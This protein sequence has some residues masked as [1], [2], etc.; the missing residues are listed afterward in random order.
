[1]GDEIKVRRVAPR[2]EGEQPRSAPPVPSS[3]L[4]E[5]KRQPTATANTTPAVES[6]LAPKPPVS[7]PISSQPSITHTEDPADIAVTDSALASDTTPKPTDNTEPSKPRRNILRGYWHHKL[8]TIPLT[9]LLLIGAFFAVPTTRYMALAYFV[10]R[11]LTVTVTDSTTHT[12][13]SGAQVKIDGQ[14]KLTGSDGKVKFTLP[15]GNHTMQVTKSYY[16][17]AHKS[18]FVD[19]SSSNNVLGVELVATGRQVPLQVINKITGKAIPEAELTIG[20]ATARTDLRGAATAVLPAD[21]A[22][23]TVIIKADGYNDFTGTVTITTDTVAANTFSMVPKGRIYFLSN[24]SGTIDVVATDLD[25]GNRKTVLA[26]TG[27][28]DKN[29]TVLLASRDW[30]Y[31]ALLSKRDGGTYAKLYLINT[32]D[33]SLATIDASAAN[34][35]LV[36]WSGH[37]FLYTIQ[38]PGVQSWQPKQQSIMS[39][40]ADTKSAKTLVDSTATGTT[41]TDAQYQDIVYTVL[42]GDDLIYTTTWY[43]YPADVVVAGHTNTMISLKPDGTGSR[44][45]KSVDAGTSYFDSVNLAAPDKLY[46]AVYSATPNY[47]RLDTNGNITQSSTITSDTVNQTYPTY[48]QS[49][50]GTA[51][52]WTSVRDGKNTLLVGDS[53]GGSGNQIVSASDYAPYGW[54]TDSYLLVQKNKSELYIMPAGGG[55]PLK[56]SDY[57]KPDYA[58]YGYGG[59]Y[60]GI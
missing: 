12:A 21:P 34:F 48:L 15:V 35:T 32:S 57:F 45:L 59:G 49:P 26:G 28:E 18:V 58:I 25:G 13:I 50:S 27:S 38:R 47:Y 14:S 17:S 6:P 4:S 23:Q 7:I 11:P 5:L 30:K 40:N 8:W 51:T 19:I 22:T 39:F 54:F 52:F 29:S 53:N 31:L 60:G 3:I 42:F 37:Y 44:T 55:T 46:F 16:Q 10:S 9:V 20:A 33:N 24:Q 1:M 56:I 2:P 36:G 41:S 43:K